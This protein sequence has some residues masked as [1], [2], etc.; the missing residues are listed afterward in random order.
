MCEL[1]EDFKHYRSI[2]LINFTGLN[3]PDATELRRRVKGLGSKWRVVKNR[4]ALRASEGTSAEQLG[5]QFQGPTAIVYS[6][7]DPAPLAKMIK[8]F[9]RDHPEMS[10]KAGVIDK[11][12]LSAKD[13][14][15]LADMPSREE[16]SAHFLRLLNTP[17]T[18]LASA[19][20]SSLRDLIFILGNLEETGK[21]Q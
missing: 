20:Q 6:G 16:I 14:D 15:D 7:D 18:R 5:L 2:L 13:V 19:L 4:L 10:F 3:V 21:R 17:L 8:D 12:I 11:R 1:G 9:M